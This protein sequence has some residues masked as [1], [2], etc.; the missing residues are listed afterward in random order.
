MAIRDIGNAIGAGGVRLT[1]DQTRFGPAAAGSVIATLSNP[2]EGATRYEAVGTVPASLGLAGNC[3]VRGGEA[4]VDGTRYAVKIRAISADGTREAAETLSFVGA[5][6]AV[7]FAATRFGLNVGRTAAAVAG[8]R[9]FATRRS[10]AT[11]NWEVREARFLFWNGS[12]RGGAA[13]GAGNPVTIERDGVR[14][15]STTLPLSYGGVQGCVIPDD[16]L[17]LS[18]PL[19]TPLAANSVFAY[20]SAGNVQ[21]GQSYVG[22]TDYLLQN[23]DGIATGSTSRASLVDSGAVG[24]GFSA[25]AHWSPI[26]M[27]GK[28]WDGS[29]VVLVLG[30]SVPAG[31][32]EPFVMADARGNRGFASKMLDDPARRLAHANYAVS[33]LRIDQVT[34]AIVPL[35]SRIAALLPNVPWTHVL[36]SLGLNDLLQDADLTTVQMRY[37]GLRAALAGLRADAPVHPLTITPDTDKTTNFWSDEAGQAFFSTRFGPA[38][39]DWSRY[40]AWIR[41]QPAGFA[42][43]IDVAP[44]V[45]GNSPDRWRVLPFQAVLT[46]EVPTDGWRPNGSAGPTQVTL[47]AAPPLGAMLVFGLGR[48][49]QDGGYIAAAVSGSG[50]YTV[51][52]LRNQI[53][54]PQAQAP[55]IAKAHAAGTPVRAYVTADGLHPGGHGHE[56][57]RAAGVAEKVKLV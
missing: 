18:D 31:Q 41:S 4:P 45:G 8:N 16:G 22:Q 19:A 54:P 24:Q 56:L 57:M 33:G 5:P 39:S 2:F 13:Q 47:D 15:G 46:A 21:V 48:A 43:P 23:G 25:G 3:I 26:A 17:V 11:P 7:T 40:N 38:P 37:G 52:L 27:V 55:T 9:F 50:P 32:V 28:G 49:D 53:Q 20:L 35:L 30:D 14:V 6:Q 1:A 36:L 51:T 29:P 12:I 10:F 44:A 42:A 34:G